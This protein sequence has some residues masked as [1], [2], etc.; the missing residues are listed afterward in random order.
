VEV[1]VRAA[2]L[3]DE[4]LYGL[5]G[6]WAEELDQVSHACIRKLELCRVREY[7][8]ANNEKELLATASTSIAIPSTT[9]N[10]AAVQP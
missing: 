7:I 3:A 6:V 2:V 10:R 9:G 4:P 8:A 5:A 1:P